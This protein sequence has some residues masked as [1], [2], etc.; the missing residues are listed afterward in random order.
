MTSFNGIGIRQGSGLIS[1]GKPAFSFVMPFGNSN[2]K[3]PKPLKKTKK[4]Q[5][6]KVEQEINVETFI[7]NMESLTNA[8]NGVK[9][10]NKTET[11]TEVKSSLTSSFKAVDV[12]LKSALPSKTEEPVQNITLQRRRRGS[13]CMSSKNLP[14]QNVT[15]SLPASRRTSRAPSVDR[16]HQSRARN[17]RSSS[18]EVFN[19]TYDLKLTKACPKTRKMSVEITEVNSNFATKEVTQNVI[20]DDIPAKTEAESVPKIESSEGRATISL[21][22]ESSMKNKLSQALT[23]L[24]EKQRQSKADLLNSNKADDLSNHKSAS[25][26]SESSSTSAVVSLTSSRR[27]SRASTP[28]GSGRRKQRSRSNSLDIYGKNVLF[29][30]Y[31]KL[32][33]CHVFLFI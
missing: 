28:G 24:Q 9:K 16:H 29:D 30:S 19:G 3:P 4:K 27:A 20:D 26:S 32:F 33:L 10:V 5:D 1:T 14:D 17:Q 12:I 6:V 23:D 8:A 18:I 11:K 7:Q 22:D 31:I 15:I 2:S 21:S 13:S 25:K